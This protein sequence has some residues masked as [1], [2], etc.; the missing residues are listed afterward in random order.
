MKVSQLYPVYRRD[1]PK[2]RVYEAP[3]RP[4]PDGSNIYMSNTEALASV[5]PT[6]EYLLRWYAQN[7]TGVYDLLDDLAGIGTMFHVLAKD[8]FETGELDL[9][10]LDDLI[11]GHI[12]KDGIEYQTQWLEP[13]KKRLMALAQ[14][15]ID[16]KVE[17]IANEIM[18]VS[19]ELQIGTAIDLV[20]RM[21]DPKKGGP[22][23]GIVDYKAGKVTEGTKKYYEGHVLQ[24]GVCRQVWNENY[25][26]G[27]LITELLRNAGLMPIDVTR[28]FNFSPKAWRTSPSYTFTEHTDHPSLAKLPYLAPLMK[29]NFQNKSYSWRKFSGKLELGKSA[30]T[31]EDA[32]YKRSGSSLLSDAE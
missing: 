23:V 32:G 1:T 16:W 5:L 8:F 25:G 29:M 14:W 28:I 26:T 22:F 27:S 4:L 3:D 21:Q 31:I 6:S 15:A 20:A 10:G 30:G 13:L 12:E 2:G 17:P 19:T 11:S 24:L 18:L 9:D 7:G